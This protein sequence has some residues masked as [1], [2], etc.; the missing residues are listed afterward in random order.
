MEIQ[1]LEL[2]ERA[3]AD[4][5]FI[6]DAEELLKSNWTKVTVANVSDRFE[7]QLRPGHFDGVATIVCKLFNLIRP[8]KAYFG[9]KDRQQCAVIRQMVADLNM[10]VG[11]SFHP[12]VRETDGL[13]LSSRNAYLSDKERAQAPCL[14]QCLLA[15]RDEILAFSNA[16]ISSVAPILS[17]GRQSLEECGFEVEYFDLIDERTFEPTEVCADNAVLITAARLGSTR[18]IDNIAIGS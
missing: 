17:N 1:D 5:V 18:L 2:A 11:L 7:G 9:E 6:P 15:A 13:A 12:T 8:H 3:G 14:Y 16:G 10:P 4:V